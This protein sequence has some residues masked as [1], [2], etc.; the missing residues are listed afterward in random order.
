VVA[1]DPADAVVLETLTEAAG[2]T[3][4]D[5][6]LDDR[7]EL[8]VADRD[9]QRHGVRIYRA[10]DGAPLTDVPINLGLAPFEIV[11]LP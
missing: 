11:F 8:F 4:A 5:I 1:F 2:F 9:R 6:E 3:L 10:A 7:G